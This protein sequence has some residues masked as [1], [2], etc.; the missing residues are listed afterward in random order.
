MSTFKKRKLN[1]LKI[2]KHSKELEKEINVFMEYSMKYRYGFDTAI[3]I[4]GLLDS[5]LT[6]E[7]SVNFALL[8]LDSDEEFEK[9][10]LQRENEALNRDEE[11]YIKD[12]NKK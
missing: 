12:E 11:I 7:D 2:L 6:S 4:D 8:M 3:N 9:E 10:L 1:L 5:L